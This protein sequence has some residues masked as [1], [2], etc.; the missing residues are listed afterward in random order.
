MQKVQGHAAGGFWRVAVVTHLE[1]LC[2]SAQT[3]VAS[4]AQVRFTRPFA[5]AQ[6]AVASVAAALASALIL[7]GGRCH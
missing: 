3:L 2:V 5:R 7:G 6:S 1:V 4:V